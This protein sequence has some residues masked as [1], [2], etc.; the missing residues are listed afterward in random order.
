MLKHADF[1]RKNPTAPVSHAKTWIA[2]TYKL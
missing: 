1:A 2:V